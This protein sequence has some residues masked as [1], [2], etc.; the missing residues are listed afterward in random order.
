MK[1][2]LQWFSQLRR[3]ITNKIQVQKIDFSTFMYGEKTQPKVGECMRMQ[4]RGC[5]T[6]LLWPHNGSTVNTSTEARSE[7]MSKRKTNKQ[8]LKRKA[9]AM[10]EA[11][12]P[13]DAGW[14]WE[15]AVCISSA[16]FCSL[17]TWEVSLSVPWV[18]ISAAASLDSL[19]MTS[20]SSPSP[21]LFDA[22]SIT[23]EGMLL[24]FS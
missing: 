3:D 22:A 9:G 24:T 23:A 6:G 19:M 4:A 14:P 13:A 21:S 16:G 11:V 15:G 20:C 12:S 10:S 1:G 2:E 5:E 18:P 17:P 7:K 8:T